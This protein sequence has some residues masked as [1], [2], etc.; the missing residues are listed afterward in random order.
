MRA[1]DRL[2]HFLLKDRLHSAAAAFLLAY[3][4]FLGSLSI[5]IAAVITL[6]KGAKEGAWVL[7]AT[8]LPFVIGFGVSIALGHPVGMA[9]LNMGV[10]VVGNGLVFLFVLLLR[11]YG[12]WSFL[13]DIALL[14]GIAVVVGLHDIYPHIDS[15]W[16]SHLTQF[17]NN[18][19]QAIGG[20]PASKENVAPLQVIAVAKSFATGFVV[21]GLL[22]NTLLQVGLAR[23]WQFLVTGK[24]RLR[25]ELLHIRLSTTTG[26]VFL[27]VA[28][29]SYWHN[30]T[31]MDLTPVVL[32]IF[33][34]AGL[35]LVHYVLSGMRHA[36]V[37]LILLYALVVLLC[38]LSIGII[39]VIGLLDVFVHF[40]KRWAIP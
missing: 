30:E 4:P 14:L 31:I 24:G 1:I 8:I 7:L 37:A 2:S 29:A 10:V 28:M 9:L 3:I 36:W 40:R 19:A 18:N 15:W 16:E 6:L 38:P 20:L 35:S 13:L 22:L 27:I 32:G 34:L 21:V 5:L 33:G 23:W 11:R 17:I 39:A 12:H 25:S 26:I